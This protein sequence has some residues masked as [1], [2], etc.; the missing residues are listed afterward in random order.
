MNLDE[1]IKIVREGWV[2]DEGNYPPMKSTSQKEKR[3][4]AITHILKHQAKALAK[5]M[6]ALER[7]DHGL[8]LD[9]DKLRLSALNSLINSLRMTDILGISPSRLVINLREWGEGMRKGM[10]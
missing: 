2:F 10:E 6:E 5:A 8:P 4:F 1:L 9:E 3:V 7:F